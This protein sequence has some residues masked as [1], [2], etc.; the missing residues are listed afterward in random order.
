MCKI[1]TIPL[2]FLGVLTALN[3]L[4]SQGP[5]PDFTVTTS[6]GQ[7]RM[8]YQDYI[9]Q[10]KVVVIEAFFTTC[11]PCAT[12]APLFQNL[13]TASL[14]A[15]PGKVEFLMLSTLITDTNVKV[16]QYKT[17]KGL[18]MPGVGKDGGSIT[19]LQPYLNGLYGPFQG[20]PT[21]IVIA[22]GT[23][24]VTFD[25]RGNSPSQTIALLQQKIEAFFPKE[26]SLENP[27]GASLEDV[28]IS[29]D[30]LAFDTAFV[31]HGAYDLSQ[32]GPLQNAAYKIK[33]FKTGSSTGL[34]TY[35]LVLM[36]K[37]ILALEPLN[38]PW[39]IVA[40]DVNCTGSITTF[41][42]VTGRKVILGI[43]DSFPC[44]SWRFMPDSAAV[45]TGNCQNFVGVQLGDVNA[46]PCNDSLTTPSDSRSLPQDLFFREHDFQA[47]ETARIALFFT[48]NAELEG[49]Q[50]A[51]E[52][53]P[54]LL[55]INTVQGEILEGFDPESYHLSEGRLALSWLQPQGQQLLA[56]SALLTLEINAAQGGKLSE[57]LRFS[58]AGLTPEVYHSEGQIRPLQLSALPAVS[59]YSISPNPAK[60]LFTVQ[61]NVEYPADFLLQ[62]LDVQGKLIF[63]K[64]VP[65]IQGLNRW[66]IE[67]GA[68]SA[69]L[70][71]LKVNGEAAGKVAVAY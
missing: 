24:A 32:V 71:F 43:L 37:H 54:D 39:Q 28:Q 70:Y 12:H 4:F 3:P 30:A 6:D 46:G 50:C 34:T 25:I 53:D 44:G 45:T 26:C 67:T 17:S 49:L 66:E 18:T 10:Q 15:H 52:F 41:D 38:C 8:L 55:K 56:G 62:L 60:G 27:F 47:G 23:G 16:A 64:T 7:V 19:A 58:Q 61:S 11:P 13:Y 42:I 14:A 63:E 35:D 65:G 57:L 29:V 51:F 5:A 36:S 31:S 40:A 59:T 48:E 22:P 20:T 9:N 68:I 69:G 21:F 1:S 33:P 2:L